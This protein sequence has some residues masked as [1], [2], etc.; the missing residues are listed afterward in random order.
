VRAAQ[1]DWIAT[2]DLALTV[3]GAAV[4]PRVEAQASVLRRGRTTLVVEVL[5][6]EVAWAMA[7]FSVLPRR[8]DTLVLPPQEEGTVRTAFGGGGGRLERWVGDAVG[9]V[10]GDRARGELT[11]PLHDYV[12]NSFGAL[13][14]GMVAF[15]GDQAGAAAI[16]AALGSPA[17]TVDLFVAYLGQ[18]KVGP[19]HTG[20]DRVAVDGRRGSAVVRV[21]DQGAGDRLTAVIHVTALA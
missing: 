7:T 14:G 5:L 11:I 1:P 6:G 17:T 3:T 13:Q 19:L 16:G 9:I 10:A 20:V 4:G 21:V 12:R 8:P 2:A 18:G 15:L